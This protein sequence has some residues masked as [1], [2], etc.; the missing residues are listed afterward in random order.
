M[1]SDAAPV[2]RG[3][4]GHGEPHPSSAGALRYLSGLGIPKLTLYLE[5]YSSCAIEGNRTGEI[6]SETLA[7][8]IAQKAVSDRYLLGLAWSIRSMEDSDRA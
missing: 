1:K 4:L 5:S 6:C 2:V 7:R 8:V 3:E